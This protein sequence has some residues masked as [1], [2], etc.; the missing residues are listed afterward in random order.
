[1]RRVRMKR[2]I[3]VKNYFI[4]AI[5]VLFTVVLAFYMRDWYNTS[6]EYYAQNSVMTKVVRE[7]KSEEESSPVPSPNISA[8]CFF[9]SCILSVPF[10]SGFFRFHGNPS[11]PDTLPPDFL[12]APSPQRYES[13]QTH[14]RRR[15]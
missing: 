7:I 10:C 15:E 2:K 9:K 1:M 3:P 5:V 13:W 6:K 11:R 12:P 14:S 4:L 8:N